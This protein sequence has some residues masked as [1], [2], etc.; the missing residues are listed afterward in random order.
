M[1]KRRFVTKKNFFKYSNIYFK[2]KL[3]I[4]F[5]FHTFLKSDKSK[6]IS[7]DFDINKADEHVSAFTEL[8]KIFNEESQIDHETFWVVSLQT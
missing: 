1:F 4:Y 8:A 3:K 2:I 5:Q 6:T 7:N